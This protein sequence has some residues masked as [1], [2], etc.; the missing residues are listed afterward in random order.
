MTH[1]IILSGHCFWTLQ[2]VFDQLIGVSN[3]ECGYI[4]MDSGLPPTPSKIPWPAHK[5]EVI[6]A[7]WDPQQLNAGDLTRFLL[8]STSAALADWE[9]LSELSGMRSLIAQMPV[10]YVSVCQNMVARVSEQKGVPLHTQIVSDILP[11]APAPVRDQ[12]FFN[13]NPNDGYSCGIILPKLQRLRG[14]FGNLMSIAQ[15]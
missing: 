6:R 12:T 13:D 5:M 3:I 2:A 11:F 8:S 4:Y 10:E 1:T 7:Q 9:T 14:E 15:G